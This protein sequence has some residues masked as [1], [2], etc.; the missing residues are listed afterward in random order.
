MEALAILIKCRDMLSMV[1][2][3]SPTELLSSI[4]RMASIAR[5]YR[6]VDGRLALFN[7]SNEGN[8]AF[9]EAVL[10]GASTATHA[11]DSAPQ[12]GFE[13]IVSGDTVVILDAGSPPL[14]K[15]NAH[16]H[17][18]A[19]SFEMSYRR[20][21]LIVN[22]GAFAGADRAWRQAQRATAA[23][24]T[25]TVDDTNSFDLSEVEDISGRHANT[26]CHRESNDGNIWVT[27]THEGYQRNFALTHQRRLY[28]SAD[29][30]DM[31]GEDILVGAYRGYFAARFHL[32]PDVRA[33][34][35]QNGAAVLMRLK[36]GIAW[37]LQASGGQLKVT[38]SV[39][40]G[41]AG[42][43]R[44][45]EQVV[46]SGQLAGQGA[47]IKWALRRLAET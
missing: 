45:S 46:I 4:E 32:H 33:S 27:V 21:R 28:I 31:R 38:E 18:G 36:S 14:A 19:L 12:A 22:C 11:P 15:S 5:L 17:A 30:Q 39:Y 3:D 29:G 9:I 10:A 43:R 8:E 13:R 7:G 6:H 47:Q 42:R 23:H 20:E 1:Q 35:V 41:C 2:R 24:S 44:R 26:R 25:V 40:L 37:R 16:S 34:V